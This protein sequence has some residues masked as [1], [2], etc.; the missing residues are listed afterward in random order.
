MPFRVK[1]NFSLFSNIALVVNCSST[2]PKSVDSKKMLRGSMPPIFSLHCITYILR[3]FYIGILNLKMYLL[4][5]MVM[6]RL[7]ILACRRKIFKG[8]TKGR[9]FV[10]R[11]NIWHPR[12][13]WIKVMVKRRTGG[14]LEE[15]YMRC[16]AVSHH[17]TARI[18]KSYSEISSTVSLS[19]TSPSW[20]KMLKTFVPNC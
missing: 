17:F 6:W 5:L 16:F 8:M 10:E 9:V 12:F 18:R 15:S 13:C 7:P 4:L 1:A 2:C 20:V 14:R 3:I 19:L 11:L